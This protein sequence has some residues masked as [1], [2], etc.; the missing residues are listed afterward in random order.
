M[1]PTVYVAHLPTRSDPVTGGPVPTINLQ[2]AAR[3]GELNIINQSPDDAAEEGFPFAA[4]RI[5]DALQSFTAEDYIL[6]CGDSVLCAIAIHEAMLRCSGVKVLRWNRT[7][8]N[9]DLLTTPS[10]I[11]A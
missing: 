7:A 4:Q 1:K 9:Y 11:G 3:I 5:R 2:P 10:T 6:M 8:R